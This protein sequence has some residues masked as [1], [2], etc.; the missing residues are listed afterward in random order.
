MKY[1]LGIFVDTEIFCLLNNEHLYFVEHEDA[2]RGQMNNHPHFAH[3]G[4]VDFF[5]QT[6][7]TGKYMEEEE[8]EA[9]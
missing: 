4:S 6:L 8:E 1:I 3:T 7:S 2:V 5:F 9:K